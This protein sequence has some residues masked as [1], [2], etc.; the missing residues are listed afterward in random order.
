MRKQLSSSILSVGS[1]NKTKPS[2]GAL[3]SWRV[4]ALIVGAVLLAPTLVLFISNLQPLQADQAETWQHVQTYKIKSAAKE[5]LILCGGSMLGALLL[6]LPPA[7]VLAK[8]NFWGQSIVG[9]L[10]V[11]PLAIPAYILALLTTDLKES[12]IPLLLKIRAKH[13][14]DT[15]LLAE[16]ISRYGIL[17]IIFSVVLY[18]YVFL[19][20]RSAFMGNL[21][22]LSEASLSLKRSRWHTFWRIQLP[23]ARPAL[24]TSLFL[25][26]MEVLNDYGA[27]HH[28]GF[29]TFTVELFRTW[30]SLGELEVAQRLA[31]WILGGVLVIMWLERIQRGRRKFTQQRQHTKPSRS[32]PNIFEFIALGTP[33]ILGLFIPLYLLIHWMILSAK[34]LDTD[35]TKTLVSSLFNSLL[36][37]LTVVA[38][39]IFSALLIVGAVRYTRLKGI[40]AIKNILQIVGYSSPGVIMA[41]GIL[42]IVQPIRNISSIPWFT[43]FTSTTI[44]LLV[45][46]LSCRYYSVASQMV[47]QAL[48]RLPRSYD[49]ASQS[50]GRSP[51]F[52]F[53]R[54]I[55]PL[56]S[57]ALFGASALV[58]VD[59]TK[60][61]PLSL[62][63]R[64]F[65]FETLGTFAYGFVDQGQLYNCAFP[66]ALLIALCMAGLI[67]VE[68]GGWRK[69]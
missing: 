18:P 58:F 25:V 46:A 34:N 32:I 50:L 53:I 16:E 20:A 14:I 47:T 49:E 24:V 68:Y 55:I 43:T 51:S 54:T 1:K 26:C 30:F 56:I 69:K 9:T 8:R 7:W 28:F 4:L 63:L 12:R 37:G 23:L 62:L 22:N 6:G 39:T 15:Y 35:M 52:G 66:S 29:S 10:L 31:C 38:I 40:V 11:L 3:A 60:E 44:V 36:L 33:V 65:D 41:I 5:T 67:A 19:A 27:V 48:E 61:L 17:I 42:S 57:P 2:W 21:K 64:P 13:G 59:V 45:F